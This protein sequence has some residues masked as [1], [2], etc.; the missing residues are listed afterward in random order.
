MLA[1]SR[2]LFI[3][4]TTTGT[5]TG[6]TFPLENAQL[7]VTSNYIIQPGRSPLYTFTKRFPAQVT[8]RSYTFLYKH[9]ISP[10]MGERDQ[11]KG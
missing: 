1:I 6:L 3:S 5:A 11:G 9:H 8:Y 10:L 4:A 2:V 7:Y